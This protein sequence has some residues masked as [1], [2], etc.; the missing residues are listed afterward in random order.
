MRNTRLLFV[1]DNA[2]TAATVARLLGSDPGHVAQ[3]LLECTALDGASPVELATVQI[4]G[5]TAPHAGFRHVRSLHVP[6]HNVTVLSLVVVDV[7]GV[8]GLADAL[9]ASPAELRGIDAV[10]TSILPRDVSDAAERQ[11][12]VQHV[13]D[14][15]KALRGAVVLAA[16]AQLHLGNCSGADATVTALR[17]ALGEV[18]VAVIPQRAIAAATMTPLPERADGLCGWCGDGASASR[19]A[20]CAAAAADVVVGALL[21]RLPVRYASVKQRHLRESAALI[22]A[23]HRDPRP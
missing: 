12:Y 19:A 14:L 9:L 15:K 3:C 18:G 22:G 20:L 21:S 4:G 6:A 16:E 10:V 7:A 17:L 2:T 11:Q 5:S 13:A 8:A 23:F 1:G